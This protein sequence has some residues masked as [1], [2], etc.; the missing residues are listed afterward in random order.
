MLKRIIID[1]RSHL[2]TELSFYSMSSK[3]KSKSKSIKKDESAPKPKEEN[4]VISLDKSN[5]IIV[6]ILAKPGAKQNGITGITDEG[7]GVQINAP[8]SEGEANTELVKY[9]A[10][11]LGLRKSDVIFDKGFKSR[12][13]T[14]RITGSI[15]IEQVKN[16]IEKEIGS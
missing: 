3:G 13:K 8:P 6:Q 12:N 15:T 11:V 10:S 4:N 14:L 2:S 16:K 9:F 1:V 7:V 5:N